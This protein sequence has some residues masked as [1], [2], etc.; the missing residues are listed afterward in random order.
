METKTILPGTII[1]YKVPKVHSTKEH[2]E[3]FKVEANINGK[4]YG[5]Q[6]LNIDKKIKDQLSHDEKPKFEIIA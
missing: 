5:Q 2:L 1:A 6:I 3:V 4:L